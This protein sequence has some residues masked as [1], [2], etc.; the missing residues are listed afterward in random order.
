M[1]DD[2]EI[3]EDKRILDE[4]N[5]KIR[6]PEEC[7]RLPFEYLTAYEK[8]I[9]TKCIEQ[10]H[11]NDTELTDLKKLLADYRPLIKRYDPI[12]IE[13]NLEE[14]VKTITSS[15]ELLRLLDDPN[16]YRF[17]MH[18]KVNGE[19]VRL[20][21][22]VKPVSDQEYIELLDVQTRIFQDLDKKEKLVYSK[23]SNQQKL[24]KEEENMFNHIQE[25]IVDKFGDVDSNNNKIMNFL[26][27]HVEFVE[28]SQLSQE[29]R[30]QFW[31]SMDVG[32]RA[33][34]YNKCKDILRIDEELEVDLFPSPR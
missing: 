3:L 23:V 25:K 2:N 1:M 5:L 22:R 30:R 16:R 34:I 18:Y 4:N 20:Q 31:E 11:L 10:E 6:F 24:T 19:I 29:A 13:E 12:Q 17:D 33:L 8:E 21:F 28:D 26:V 14:N 32:T 27:D 15:R 9:V 7:K